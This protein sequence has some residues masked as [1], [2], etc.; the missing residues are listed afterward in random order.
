MEQNK[1]KIS[2]L[3]KSN[4]INNKQPST[5][6]SISELF[7][8]PKDQFLSVEIDIHKYFLLPNTNNTYSIGEPECNAKAMHY[9]GMLD[10]AETKIAELMALNPEKLQRVLRLKKNQLIKKYGICAAVA[11]LTLAQLRTPY[12]GETLV[13]LAVRKGQ[14]IFLEVLV[15][16]YYREGVLMEEINR[17]NSLG[18]SPFYYATQ[19]WLINHSEKSEQIMLYLLKNGAVP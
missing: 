11:T 14:R 8:I 9:N 17:V 10:A 5:D 18:H 4:E 7:A 13:Q 6:Q 12:E 16:R 2:S 19:N 15:E 3:S 1:N